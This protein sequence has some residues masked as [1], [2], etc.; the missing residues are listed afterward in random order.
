MNKCP[1][2]ARWLNGNEEGRRKEKRGKKTKT[3]KKKMLY[4]PEE[5][6]D[7]VQQKEKGISTRF[8]R[9][10]GPRSTNK[11]GQL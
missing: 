5:L 11:Y 9:T 8:S 3:E 2:A 10:A 4:K 6:Q 1:V 7:I